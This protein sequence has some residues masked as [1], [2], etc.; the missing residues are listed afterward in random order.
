VQDDQSCAHWEVPS[1]LAAN[2]QGG[3]T[4]SPTQGSSGHKPTSAPGVGVRYCVLGP[5]GRYFLQLA[6]GGRSIWV[7]P[8]TFTEALRESQSLARRVAFGPNDGWFIIFESGTVSWENIPRRLHNQILKRATD[9]ALVMDVSIGPK[10]EFFVIY[11]D[12][13][14]NVA[15]ISD[16]LARKIDEVHC[17]RG[18]IRSISFGAYDSWFIRYYLEP[19]G[20]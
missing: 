11:H 3:Y 7:G 19:K 5:R 1:A 14:W 6:E 8:P 18:K 17:E 16:V 10:G 2:L 15:G 20:W 12:F 9:D 13:T 4:T